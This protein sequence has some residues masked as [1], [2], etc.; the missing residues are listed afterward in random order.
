M[1]LANRV[2]EIVAAIRSI[3]FPRPPRQKYDLITDV[4][5]KRAGRHR[6]RAG[7]ESTEHN[8]D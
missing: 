6:I 7:A 2:R 8:E 1:P 4:I 3:H 5:A